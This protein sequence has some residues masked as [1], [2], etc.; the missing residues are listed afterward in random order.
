[1][2]VLKRKEM[3]S[4]FAGVVGLN[5]FFINDSASRLAMFCSHIGQALVVKDSTVKRLITGMEREYGEDVHAVRMP[6]N[7]VIVKI[8]D[9]YQPALGGR[10]VG[11][12]PM[13]A[14]IYE[15]IDSPTREF[16]VLMVEKN[17]C[18]H[19]HYGFNYVKTDILNRLSK[20][21]H[22]PAG[23]VL[24][25]SPS[26]TPQGDYK[27]G[28][29]AQVAY[30]SHPAVIEDG[31]IASESFCRRMATKGYGRR[32]VSWGKSSMPV[33]LFGDESVFKPFP[34]VGERVGEDGL[35]FAS[36]NYDEL[37]AP[38]LM[39]VKSLRTMDYFDKP[40]HAVSNVKIVDIVVLKGNKEKTMLPK[41]MDDFP[42]YYYEKGARFYQELLETHRDLVRRFGDS[43]HLSPK[44]HQMLVHAESVLKNDERR[45]ITPTYRGQTLDEWVVSITFEYD[46]I[47][48]IGYKLTGLHGDKGVICAVWPDHRMP[49]DK[50]GRRAELIMDGDSTFKRMNVGR[51][52]EQYINASGYATT[53]QVAQMLNSG[54]HDA[55]WN[56]LR[57]FY[58]IVS[59]PMAQHVDEVI[60]SDDHKRR[61]LSDVAR[62][63]HYIYMPVDNPVDYDDVVG[64]LMDEY[65][66]VCGP[67][68]FMDDDDRVIETKD[69]VLIGGV[70]ILLLEKTGHSWSGVSS[71]KLNHFGTP[72]KMTS[73]DKYASAGR[74]NPTR[75]WG[76]AEFRLGSATCGGDAMAEI[77]DRNNN[78][79]VHRNECETILSADAPTDLYMS[80]NRAVAPR[81][82]SRVL[83]FV[84]HTM[85]CGGIRMVKG[86]MK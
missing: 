85:E 47:P 70:Y 60:R 31:V 20:G 72:A 67:V 3:K 34:N 64:Q 33:N 42:R 29:E 4:K 77:S 6:C 37:L 30:M 14:I 82:G 69:D 57:R 21:D 79:S 83:S 24:A 49:V 27:F 66:A 12:N 18:L 38:S 58:E 9:K 75:G 16:G 22:I 78:P 40:V 56:Y 53:S 2:S 19:Q 84:K 17:H 23:T 41:G 74:H 13:T 51:M 68:T 44:L 73:V 55:A 36:R 48:T 32:I 45:Y 65:P 35:L 25:T 1:M 10:V 71:A 59:P 8:I 50:S 7:A 63:G 54:Q 81:G 39:S 80:V 43:V 86:G 11:E 62:N 61:H 46:V 28:L 15:N 26:I 5:P 52:W 76:E